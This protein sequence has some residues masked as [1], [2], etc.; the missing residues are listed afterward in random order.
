MNSRYYPSKDKLNAM[1]S[2]LE[3]PVWVLM[4]LLG[5][6]EGVMNQFHRAE[7]IKTC[8]AA[9]QM[10]ESTSFDPLDPRVIKYLNKKIETFNI[11]ESS[12][13]TYKRIADKVDKTPEDFKVI[14]ENLEIIFKYS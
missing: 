2:S 10:L 8:K 11:L 12:L 13:K 1:A 6:N 4:S 14:N 5:L 7:Q 3:T 9:K